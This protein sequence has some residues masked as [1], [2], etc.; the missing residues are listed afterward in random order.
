MSPLA[1]TMVLPGIN[2]AAISTTLSTL[3]SA[4]DNTTTPYNTTTPFHPTPEFYGTLSSLLPLL[5]YPFLPTSLIRCDLVLVATSL[6]NIALHLLNGLSTLINLYPTP[7]QPWVFPLVLW[8]LNISL[9]RA[10]LTL[11]VEHQPTR[12]QPG[13][14]FNALLKDVCPFLLAGY[15]MARVWLG[16]MISLAVE[17][18]AREMAGGGGGWSKGARLAYGVALGLIMV[19]GMGDICLVVLCIL[20]PMA[21]TVTRQL[22]ERS[23][24][25]SGYLRW[26]WHDRFDRFKPVWSQGLAVAVLVGVQVLLWAWVVAAGGGD[27]MGGGGSWS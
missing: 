11:P 23:V 24:A 27:V 3:L 12:G 21:A 22:A 8:T 7:F 16:Y 10:R 20:G 19:V 18:E 14:Y 15:A 6:L 5:S 13:W 26:L 17:G 4:R 2:T 9:L 25:E 1:Q